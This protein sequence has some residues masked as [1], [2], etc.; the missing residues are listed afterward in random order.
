MKFYKDIIS[1]SWQGV[2]KNKFLWFFGFFV[3]LLG[4][5]GGEYEFY[6]RN[7]QNLLERSS[8]L[9]PYYWFSNGSQSIFYRLELFINNEGVFA[10]LFL[11]LFAVA[12]LVLIYFIMISQASLVYAANKI[13]KGEKVKMLECVSHVKKK[14]FSV[15]GLNLILKGAI[16]FAFLVIGLPLLALIL[17]ASA[18]RYNTLYVVIGF[19]ILFPLSI[20]ATFLVKYA[21]NYVV[22]NDEKFFKA[23]GRGWKLFIDNWLITLEM[24]LVIFVI[25]IIISLAALAILLFLLAPYL[26]FSIL[27]I[28]VTWSWAPFTLFLTIASI[29]M[30][31]AFVLVGSIFSAFQWTA[32]TMLFDN[33][34]KEPRDSRIATWINKKKPQKEGI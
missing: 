28:S 2:K 11:F 15:L 17:G 18:E 16:Y 8:F 29:I 32:W 33:L 13:Y 20:V 34:T 24:A 1:A 25:N 27:N 31:I 10:Y 14:A 23:I 26:F 9:N 19:I 7:A 30:A 22:L 4:E 12:L 21:I 3:V 5:N 6:I